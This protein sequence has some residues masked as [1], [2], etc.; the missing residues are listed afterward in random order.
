M[1]LN[2][3]SIQ[4]IYDNLKKKDDQINA[5]TSQ[6]GIFQKSEDTTDIVRKAIQGC[7]K[8]TDDEADKL[9]TR[10]KEL[11]MKTNKKIAEF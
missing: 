10:V 2:C 9:L 3:H 5:I 8:Y 11:E 1:K 7:K 4:Y 6:L